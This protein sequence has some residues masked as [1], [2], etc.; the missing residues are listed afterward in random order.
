[1]G[2][3]KSLVKKKKIPD[4]GQ[5]AWLFLGREK[6]RNK[7]KFSAKK[8]KSLQCWQ[9]LH[10]APQG[11]ACLEHDDPFCSP[12]EGGS[13][14]VIRRHRS[15]HTRKAATQSSTQK[16]HPEP[17][18]LF[19]P[20]FPLMKWNLPKVAS[21]GTGKSVPRVN[22]WEL[23]KNLQQGDPEITPRS[24]LPKVDLPI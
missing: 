8:N 7:H 15:G 10:C 20:V 11:F 1:M 2:K 4:N 9:N 12:H 16:C 5:F 17:L 18:N 13:Q 24:I 3:K 6:E 21:L 14:K 19:L 22:C 23:C